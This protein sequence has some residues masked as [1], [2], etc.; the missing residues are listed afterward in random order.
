[1]GESEGL[2]LGL[3]RGSG[4]IGFHVAVAPEKEAPRRR[5]LLMSRLSS[6]M[7]EKK[8]FTT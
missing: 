8:N 6:D 5:Q 2:G 7:A 3:L 1:M 4:W